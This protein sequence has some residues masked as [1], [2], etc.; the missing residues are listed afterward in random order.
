M[1]NSQSKAYVILLLLHRGRK[2][3]FV[4]IAN[5]NC[6]CFIENVVNY[7]YFF[8]SIHYFATFT[9]CQR[10][11]FILETEDMYRMSF[12]CITS[13]MIQLKKN[14]ITV[15]IEHLRTITYNKKLH[16]CTKNVSLYSYNKFLLSS[17]IL[18]R[19]ISICHWKKSII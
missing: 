18:M 16:V 4:I 19:M 5:Y 8:K 10:I 2:K 12:P 1:F 17:R 3:Q 15:G 14:N 13:D 7:D 6:S 11:Q 9:F